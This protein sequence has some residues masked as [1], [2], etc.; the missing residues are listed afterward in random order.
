[1][2]GPMMLAYFGVSCSAVIHPAK[3]PSNKLLQS[4]AAKL[5]SFQAALVVKLRCW[6][7]KQSSSQAATVAHPR[8]QIAKLTLLHKIGN[9]ESQNLCAESPSEASLNHSS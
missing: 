3:Q 4:Y 8:C 7:V 9:D 5:S 1:M 6:A 2:F